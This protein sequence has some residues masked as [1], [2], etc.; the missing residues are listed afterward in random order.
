MTT[1]PSQRHGTC[2]DTLIRVLVS[3]SEVDLKKILEEYRAMYDTTLQED[4]LVKSKTHPIL[5]DY[6][7][8]K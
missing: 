2:E 6:V 4:I 7:V 5:T 8:V 3:R 1:V